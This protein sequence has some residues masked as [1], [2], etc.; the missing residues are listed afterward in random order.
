MEIKI[1]KKGIREGG[2]EKELFA[3]VECHDKHE[4]EALKFEVR[5]IFDFG[6]V[7]NPLYPIN[8]GVES[9]LPVRTEGT[10]VWKDFDR[11]H[12]WVT[13]RELTDF[14]KRCV[15]YLY[16]NPPIFDRVRL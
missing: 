5:N 16:Q 8:P 6:L 15:E 3:V 13:I 9:G 11:T 12:G 14:E 1:L 7:V 10:W 2:E 4:H